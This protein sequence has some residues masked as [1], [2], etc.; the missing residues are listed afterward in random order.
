MNELPTAYISAERLNMFQISSLIKPFP[1]IHFLL[2]V[3][4]FSIHPY[5]IIIKHVYIYTYIS[6]FS[7]SNRTNQEPTL[8][9]TL[10]HIT[11]GHIP[12]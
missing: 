4:I 11:P 9:S 2:A 5:A 1:F 6:K 12:R 8:I 10:H 3:G 7:L